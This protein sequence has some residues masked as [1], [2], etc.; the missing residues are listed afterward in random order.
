MDN[1]H[2]PVSNLE[3]EKG[4]LKLNRS[5]PWDTIAPTK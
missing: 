3:R 2:L 4:H 5:S 1:F